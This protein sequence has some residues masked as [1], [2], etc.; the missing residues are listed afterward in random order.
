MLTTDTVN[1]LSTTIDLE[2][3]L[4]RAEVLFKRFQRLVE[5]VDKKQNFPGPRKQDMTADLG[6]KGNAN[7]SSSSS[8]KQ[9]RNSATPNNG[10][11]RAQQKLP[12]TERVITPELRKLL[13]R[14]VEVLPRDTVAK[15][16]DG[17]PER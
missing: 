5:A 9:D 15:K 4:I 6:S 10:K 14:N 7:S 11:D 1:E 2:S 3:T 17:M 13:S 8:S 16:G 12:P